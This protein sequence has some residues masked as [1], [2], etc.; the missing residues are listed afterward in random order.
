MQVEIFIN[1]ICNQHRLQTEED[2]RHTKLQAPANHA[3]IFQLKFHAYIK[4]IVQQQTFGKVRAI[5]WV[6]QMHKHGLPHGH[7]LIMLAGV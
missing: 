6:I 5:K 4:V 3:N 1:M 2:V 7:I